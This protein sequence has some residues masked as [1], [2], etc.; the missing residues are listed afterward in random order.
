MDR[1][2]FYPKSNQE[3]AR[4]A[5]N[6]E[7]ITTLDITMDIAGEIEEPGVLGRRSLD[8]RGRRVQTALYAVG[9]QDE[10]SPTPARKVVE[11]EVS[12]ASESSPGQPH[13]RGPAQAPSLDESPPRQFEVAPAKRQMLIQASGTELSQQSVPY[14][15]PAP[16]TGAPMPP[17]MH[18]T[19]DSR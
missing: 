8:T 2:K 9:Q 11:L 16:A 15:T 5:V 12:P 4:Q 18:M 10:E 19:Q 6:K 3:D 1:V 17:S 14:R 13:G 7:R